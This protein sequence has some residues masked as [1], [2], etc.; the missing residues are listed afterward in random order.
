[1]SLVREI[2][3]RRLQQMVREQPIRECYL[4]KEEH[5]FGVRYEAGSLSFIWHIQD[6]HASIKRGDLLIETVSL[7]GGSEERRAA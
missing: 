3:M 7:V 2:A 6:D 4:I 1:M 5:F